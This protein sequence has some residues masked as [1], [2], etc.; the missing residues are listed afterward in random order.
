LKAQVMQIESN[1]PTDEMAAQCLFCMG[2][3]LECK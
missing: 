3:V 2:A 1:S